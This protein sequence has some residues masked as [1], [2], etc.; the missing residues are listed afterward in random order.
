MATD[1]TQNYIDLSS[2][3][4][5]LTVLM[6]TDCIIYILLIVVVSSTLFNWL[7]DVFGSLRGLI[8]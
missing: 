3:N 4:V 7:P 2:E 5:F 6:A 1:L 8:Y